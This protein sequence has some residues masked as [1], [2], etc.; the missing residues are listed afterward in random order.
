[1]APMCISIQGLNDIKRNYDV[2][3]KEM[4]GIIRVLEAWRHYLEGAKHEIDVWT[5]HQNLK[6]FMTAKK[7][8][9][10]QA[11]WALFVRG[12]LKFQHKF[13]HSNSV[14]HATLC[15]SCNS[16]QSST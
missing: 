2:H 1:M 15:D 11:H 14:T 8:N 3:D 9:H 6:Y 16:V 12:T 4:L 7:L 10:Q 13:Q 5:D